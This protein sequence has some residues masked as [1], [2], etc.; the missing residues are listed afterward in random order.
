MKATIDLD[1]KLRELAKQANAKPK[2]LRQKVMDNAR[3]ACEDMVRAAKEHTPNSGDGKK[4]GLNMISNS[5]QEA[6][7][8]D[9]EKSGKRSQI[10]KVVLSNDKPY[11][12]FVQNGYNV[13]KHFV[14]WLYKDNDGTLSYETN[15]GQPLFGI[16]VGTKTKHVAGVDMV[17]PATKA[18][19]ETFDKLNETLLEDFDL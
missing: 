3:V 9:I 13:T 5:L 6:W 1:K 14:P 11:A 15:H 12:P 19:N 10:G 17:G 2:E 8:A 7:H 4:R 18:F 16:V